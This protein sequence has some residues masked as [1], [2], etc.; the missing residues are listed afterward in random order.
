M[1][2]KNIISEFGERVE[3]FGR[4]ATSKGFDKENIIK[5]ICIIACSEQMEENYG[6]ELKAM[7]KV[8]ELCNQIDDGE[9]LLQE[10]LLLAGIE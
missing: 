4:L 5:P 3:K 8:I 10:V 7:D 6:D 2:S 9:K 1:G